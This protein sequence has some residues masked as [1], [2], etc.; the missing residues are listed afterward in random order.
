M[1]KKLRFALFGNEYQTKKSASAA[2][3]LGCLQQHEAEVFVERTFYDF[4]RQMHG[5]EPVV[6]ALCDS[7][8]VFDVLDFPV[9]YAISMGGDGTLLK[10]ASHVGATGIPI[11]GVNTGRLGF[12]ADFL[13]NEIE[14]ALDE[15]YAGKCRVEEHAAIKLSLR[16]GSSGSNGSFSAMLRKRPCGPSA[17]SL[18]DGSKGSNGSFSAMLRKRPCGPSAMSLRDGSKGSSGSIGYPYALNDIAVLKR[19]NASMITIHARI[20]GDELVT[21]QADGLVVSTPTGSTAYNLSNGG[22][23]MAPLT[24]ILCLTPVAPHSLN[25]RPI[26]INDDSVIELTVESRTH[27]YLVAVDGRSATLDERIP[28]VISKAP[29]TVRIVKRASQHYFATL[30]EK[31]MWGVDAR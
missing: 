2:L 12:L 4:L 23:I 24:G 13:P 29:Y 10:T 5:G 31:M 8:H 27:N 3:L 11:I 7:M 14:Q 28:L 15:L 30:R 22:P 18:R 9:D 16:D 26:V 21:Y 19:D 25:I 17:M 6:A 20:N 1:E